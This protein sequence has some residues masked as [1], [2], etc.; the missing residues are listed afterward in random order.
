MVLALDATRR[1]YGSKFP[2]AISPA[3]IHHSFTTRALLTP[4]ALNVLCFP[5]PRSSVHKTQDSSPV[6]RWEAA[7]GGNKRQWLPVVSNTS[8]KARSQ[9]YL[10]PPSSQSSCASFLR[11][12]SV[13]TF[14]ASHPRY[15]SR[16]V[17]VRQFRSNPKYSHCQNGVG[18]PPFFRPSKSSLQYLKTTYLDSQ[19]VQ[20]VY[21]RIKY[22]LSQ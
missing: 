5:K 11:F 3:R 14:A 10:N 21:I 9:V 1:V 4:H 16:F 17:A 18:F 13:V 8:T 12:E 7:M 22:S 6:A 15:L 20:P 2:E 19:A